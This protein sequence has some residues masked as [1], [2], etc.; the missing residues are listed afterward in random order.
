[1]DKEE[2]YIDNEGDDFGVFGL[3]TGFC[4]L[5]TMH[6]EH[7]IEFAYDMNIARC[8]DIAKIRKDFIYRIEDD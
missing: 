5:L 2:V 6:Q 1:M 8:R 4:Y 7:A 3:N